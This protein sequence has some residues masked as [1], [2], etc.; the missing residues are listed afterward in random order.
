[1]NGM[2]RSHAAAILLIIA[3][4]LSAFSGCGGDPAGSVPSGGEPAASE[5][6]ASAPAES[7]LPATSEDP[8]KAE[9]LAIAEELGIDEWDIQGEYALFVKFCDTVRNNEHISGFEQFVYSLFPVVADNAYLLDEDYFFD[10]LSRLRI[11]TVTLP[12]RYAG[13]YYD[14]ITTAYYSA[15][16]DGD[17]PWDTS[18]LYHEL[19]HFID[20]TVNGVPEKAYAAGERVIP[21]SELSSLSAAERDSAYMIDDS[22]VITESGAELF[23]A[24]YFTGA[25]YAYTT[26]TAFLTGI[27]YIFGTET[28][29]DL[30]F[31]ADSSVRFANFFIDEGYTLNDYFAIDRTLSWLT[32]PESFNVP[33]Q[34]VSLEDVLIDLYIA[35]RGEDWINDAN[36]VYVLKAING[37]ALNDYTASKYADELR[38][39]EYSSIGEYAVFEGELID[40]LGLRFGFYVQP[41][42]P[43]IREGRFLIGAPAEWEDPDTGETVTGNFTLEID[44]TTNYVSWY[45]LSDGAG[46][47]SSAD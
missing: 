4:M 37:V 46:P 13:E 39:I 47:A 38:E 36:F 7:P 19:M 29:E 42:V 24:K 5:A 22:H 1:M 34:L 17:H 16:L 14:D 45:E 41:P 2:K 26:G 30:F 6:V 35:H 25:P 28:M 27:E 43:F 40:R 11:D 44:L 21:A 33:E 18:A 15:S 32:Y 20:Y 12:E 31:P 23:T 9:A 3:L 10:K 8:V